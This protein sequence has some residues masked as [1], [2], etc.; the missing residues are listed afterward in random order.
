MLYCRDVKCD[1]C[2]AKSVCVNI[3]PMSEHEVD[4][5]KEKV[6]EFKRMAEVMGVEPRL[7]IRALG[8]S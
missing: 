2:Y 5:L 7:L 1:N 3:A 6:G 8:D 4:A